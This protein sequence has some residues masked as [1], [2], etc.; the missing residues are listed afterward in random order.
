MYWRETLWRQP[1]LKR[2][3]ALN[4]VVFKTRAAVFYR[5]LN[6]C[7]WSGFRSDSTWPAQF[8]IHPWLSGINI[9]WT[10][11][12]PACF[13]LTLTKA[14]TSYLQKFKEWKFFDVQIYYLFYRKMLHQKPRGKHC[15]HAS[16]LPRAETGVEQ[17]Q[18]KSVSIGSTELR[19]YIYIDVDR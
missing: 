10:S 4:Y 13:I 18:Y 12:Y 7:A 19:T 6:S 16:C 2:S 14:I 15:V 5:V 3:T 8:I 11:K 17:L 9:P 1:E